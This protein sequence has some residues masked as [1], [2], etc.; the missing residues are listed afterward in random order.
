MT[1][2]WPIVRL[3]DLVEIKHGFAFKGEY[4]TEVP[5]ENVLL[6]PG[7]F[8]IGGGY[9]GEKLKYYTG[10]V[11]DEFVLHEGDLIVTMTDLSKAADTLG[12]P[13]LVPHE[14]G[15]KFL[16]NQ[17]LGRILLKDKNQLDLRYLYFLLCSQLYRNEVLASVTGTTVKHTSPKKIA[18]FTLALP[19]LHEQQRIAHILGILDDKINLNRRMNETLELTARTI[20]Q[21]WFTDFDPV[22]TKAEGRH[23]F[24]MDSETAALF[25][26]GFEE[27]EI[28]KVPKRWQVHSIGDMVDAVGGATPSTKEPSYWNGEV[29]FATPKEMSSLSA[30]VLLETDRHITEEA[31]AKI[32][33]GILPVGTVLLSSRA[34]IGY[35]AIT[36]VPVAVNQGIIA[37]ICN[38]DLPN[39]YVLNWT[40][41]N[42]E[43]I[44]GRANG[45]TFLEISKKSFRPIKL[46][47]PP[48][49]LLQRFTELVEPLYKQ[50]TL[51]IKET[52]ALAILRDVLFPKLMSG[53]LSL[54]NFS[55]SK[56]S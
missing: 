24:G 42:M 50:V 21:S 27:S 16:H 15:R 25:P 31:V 18:A 53:E 39:Y 6:T 34:P 28:G 2:P 3:G 22:S 52:Q 45:T 32:S 4:F 19:T 5:N 36:E 26:D 1:T 23:P 20:F 11:D 9:K 41:Q 46:V 29:C 43:T 40:A 56:A 12:Y 35:L 49:A 13:A 17:R 33:S 48:A 54:S 14:P 10:S 37:M 55:F 38:R 51:N 47:V 30:P 7:N 44:I 8:R